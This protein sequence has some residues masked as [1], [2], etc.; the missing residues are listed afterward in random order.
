M[1]VPLSARDV[2][3]WYLPAVIVAVAYYV[4]AMLGLQLQLPGTNSSPVWPPSGIGFAAVMLWG[5]RVWPGIAVGAFLAN[6]HTLPQTGPGLATSCGICVGNTLE[7]LIGVYLLRRWVGTRSPFER[8]RD[9]FRFAGVAAICCAIASTNGT[10]QLVLWRILP[11]GVRPADVWLT[12]WLG[13][14]AGILI[15]APVIQSW[16]RTEWQAWRRVQGIE[17]A[18][19]LSVLLA[20]SHVLFGGWFS[21]SAPLAFLILPGLLGIAFQ[22][23]QR[24]SS[25]AAALVSGMAIW[26]TI[27]GHG[28]FARPEL[29]ESLLLLQVFVCTIAMTAVTLAAAVAERKRSEDELRTLNLTLEQRVTDRTAE[30]ARANLELARSNQE[31]DDFAY[32]T[33]HDLKE[34]LRGI[35]NFSNF[36]IEDAGDKLDDDGRSKL[37]T[38]R[39]LAEHMETLLSTLLHF[40]RVGRTE[41]AIQDTKL[42]DVLADVLES[43]QVRLQELKVEV[44]IPQPLPTLRCDRVRVGEVFRNL[45]TNAMKY[46][47]KPQKWMEI[48]WR[49]ESLRSASTATEAASSREHDGTPIPPSNSSAGTLLPD[50]EPHPSC[51][52]FF[53]RDNGIG[54]PVQHRESIFRIF[55]R[56]HARDKFG[57]G[58]GAGLTIVKKIIER[59]GGRIWVESAVDEGTA[60][61]FTLQPE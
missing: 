46:N 16:V 42:N 31:L 24:E 33:S 19:V 17:V 14:T 43:L 52:L 20:I 59:H 57:G 23:G 6:L 5:Y 27:H 8:A 11:T 29:N 56:L 25:T 38:V 21:L 40:S 61:F 35:A 53:V 32:I 36:V 22:F 10:G 9:V 3:T 28:P 34:P 30:L 41:L 26:H 45:I 4:A 13:D 49:R 39:R 1:K 58:T 60:F 55:K 51:V 12:W 54:I 2:A 18:V 47:D 50:G 37:Q 48:G 7:H 15:L 44:R